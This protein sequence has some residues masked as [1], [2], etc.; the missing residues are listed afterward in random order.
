[1]NRP[2]P[3][4]AL[5]AV[6]IVNLRGD[7]LIERQYRSDISRA[8]ID[9]FKTEILSLSASSSS[10]FSGR[11]S[12]NGSSK[13][14]ASTTSSKVDVQS[15]PPIRIVGQIRFMFIRVANVYV[16]AATKLNVNVSMCFAFLK[17]AI[18]TFQVRVE[19]FFVLLLRVF[20]QS[21]SHSH[22]IFKEEEKDQEIQLTDVDSL[23]SLSLSLRFASVSRGILLPQ[24]Y[25]GKVNENNIRANF[26]LMYELFD[27]MCDNGY[28]Q[29]TSANVL[30]EFI[31][32][33]ASVMD[34]IEGKLNNKGDNGQMKSS[35]D[36]KE[37]AMNK[38]ARARQTTAQ[39]TGSVQWRRPGL[40][41]KKNE[42]YLDVIETISCVT[43][44]NGD[45]LRASCSGRVVLNA[46]L[47]GMP[48]LKIGLNDSLGD[49]AKGGRNNPNAVDAGGDGK[50]M[51]FRGMPSLANKR[52]TIDLDDLQ[53]HHCVNLS[54]FASDK[55]VSF[56]PPDGEFE[57]MKYRVSEN[58]SIPFKVIAM[59]KELGRTRVSVD[60]M[61]KSVFAE[62]TVAQEIR[63][64][65]PVPPN[66]AKVKVLCSGGKARY[67]AGEECLRWKIK[68]LPGGKEI[69][70]QAE[71]ML[72]GSIKD[73]ADD[74]KS[75]GKKKWSQPPLNVQFSLPMFTAS[76]LRIR[77]LKVW[78]KEGYE[79]TKWVRYLTTAASSGHQGA[80]AKLT[81]S[82]RKKMGDFEVRVNSDGNN[83]YN[84]I[85]NDNGES[86]VLNDNIGRLRISN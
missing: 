74:K 41:Y 46:K 81:S 75:G 72:V 9:M 78:S 55:V 58:V 85:Y 71:V 65:I 42:V 16:C 3:P 44:A 83:N 37:E 84:N 38:L 68:N 7:V 70:L 53:F 56:V 59:V 25:F 52:K 62:K 67:L 79:A 15:L 5:S 40:M 8:N 20:S 33:K 35:K 27:E 86:S 45:A 50:D 31:T 1:M 36:E 51:D 21:H 22:S 54:K 61:F 34:I 77:F 12:S 17:S 69:R 10:P 66:T 24:S 4:I 19:L 6:F 60:V 11:K 18:G 57:L 2:P 82:E 43:Q 73:D 23:F 39:M 64:R 63:V 32:Q 13:R 49:E 76:G 47:S 80:S 26:V 29:I 28:P 48:E 14:N 30:K